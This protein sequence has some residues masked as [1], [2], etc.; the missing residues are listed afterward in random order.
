MVI[1]LRLTRV[2]LSLWL[3]ISPLICLYW[4][5]RPDE[6][7]WSRHKFISSVVGFGGFWGCVFIFTWG[8]FCLLWFIPNNS[9]LNLPGSFLDLDVEGEV[10]MI[11]CLLAALI[12]FVVTCILWRKL[13]ECCFAKQQMDKMDREDMCKRIELWRENHIDDELYTTFRKRKEELEELQKEG[14]FDSY[15]ED[16]LSNLKLVLAERD[17]QNKGL[18]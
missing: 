17:K 2:L 1:T 18:P 15:N 9:L 7:F 13:K 10:W 12:G 3:I 5:S 16:E 14:K 6:W 11:K 8:I 4:V